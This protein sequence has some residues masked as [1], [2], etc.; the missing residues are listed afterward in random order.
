MCYPLAPKLSAQ[1]TKSGCTNETAPSAERSPLPADQAVPAVHPDEDDEMHLLSHRGLDLSALIKNGAVQPSPRAPSARGRRLRSE[2]IRGVRTPSSPS[3][4]DQACVRRVRREQPR[5]PD[6]QAP[7]SQSTM[8]SPIESIP[9]VVDDRWCR[10]GSASSS[11]PDPLLPNESLARMF[12]VGEDPRRRVGDRV[13]RARSLPGRRPRAC[14][15][16]DL[17]DVRGYG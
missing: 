7:V 6:L 4:R 16:I 11:A 1:P 17:G 14:G 10:T 13:Q 9:H 8:S 2:C 15:L 5:H 12:P 3:V